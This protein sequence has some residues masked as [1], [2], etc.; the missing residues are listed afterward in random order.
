M[1]TP[2]FASLYLRVMKVFYS[3]KVVR[4]TLPAL[5]KTRIRLLQKR[6]QLFLLPE[7]FSPTIGW[8]ENILM[9]FASKC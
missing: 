7:Q 1:F 5:I 6:L 8:H 2:T 4:N 9:R 3:R